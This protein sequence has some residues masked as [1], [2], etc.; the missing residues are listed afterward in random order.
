MRLLHI[1]LLDQ[2]RFSRT[3]FDLSEVDQKNLDYNILI[4]HNG[5]VEGP[6]KANSFVKCSDGV[7]RLMSDSKH[8]I[9]KIIPESIKQKNAINQ[10][11]KRYKTLKIVPNYFGVKA[12]LTNEEILGF[13]HIILT[14]HCG[15]N[16]VRE[17]IPDK[18]MDKVTYI[19]HGVAGLFLEQKRWAK[20]LN[21]WSKRINYIVADKRLYNLLEEYLKPKSLHLIN[22]LPQFDHAINISKNKN[23][24]K[25]TL[26][27]TMQRSQSKEDDYRISQLMPE[28]IEYFSEKFNKVIIKDK[29]NY[30]SRIKS[31][32]EFNNN[33]NIF[34]DSL[35]D[36]LKASCVLHINYGTAF[37]ES[38]LV[39][40]RVFL[41]E[42]FHLNQLPDCKSIQMTNSVEGLK[43]ID[44]N[45]KI[46]KQDKEKFLESELGAKGVSMFSKKAAV[47]LSRIIKGTQF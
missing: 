41:F 15:E 44:L 9:E 2:I 34:D 20:Y 45:K 14:S 13:D 28:I 30:F 1:V 46:T 35:Y 29:Q 22:G 5:L 27:I 21:K 38:L 42:P 31:N 32:I 16:Y 8:L 7:H 40:D 4:V 43:K 36:Y 39:N 6:C 26:L 23:K 18:Y 24:L 47:I 37:I 11:K 33:M 17:M 25:S 19:H 10:I 12:F 3:L